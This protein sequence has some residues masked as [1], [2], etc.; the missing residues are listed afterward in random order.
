[1]AEPGPADP[2]R[3]AQVSLPALLGGTRAW[4]LAAL[5]LNGV[6][7]AGT[8]FGTTL[9]VQE[10]FSRLVAGGSRASL[11][12]LLPL[13]AA[14]GAGALLIG[15]LRARERA[16]GER[17]GQS[18]V[19]A[20]RH[21]MYKRLSDL[22]PR[23]L[24]KRSQGAVMLRFVGDLTSIARWVSLGLSR[25]IV[26]GTF[27][28]GA[29]GALAFLSPALAGGVAVIL[30]LG[31]AAALV[32]ARTL[33]ARSRYARRKRSALAANV[34]EK[35][36]AMA[37]VQVYGQTERE[38]L[39]LRSQSR[40]LRSAMVGKAQAAGRLRGITEA[41]ALM[42]SVVALMVGAAQVGSGALTPGTIVAA[43]MIIGLLV[44]PLR[45][46][47]RV[48]EYWHDS[49]ISLEK[50]RS[51]LA[52][53]NLVRVAPDAPQL[54]PGSGR[55]EFDDVYLQGS[56]F[57]VSAVAEPRSLV[58]LVGPNGAGKSTL[59]MLAARL[60]DPDAG[61]VRV[62]GQDLAERDRSSIREAIS[63]TGPDFPLLRGTVA[64]NLCYRSPDASAAELDRV[65][66][67]CSLDGLLS[68]LPDGAETRVVEGGTNLSAG[69]RQRIALA[70]ALVGDPRLLL[71]DEADANLDE[72]A[73]G[74]LERI[75]RTQRG[76]RTIL[77]VSHRPEVL[78]WADVI[79]RMEGGR[80][81]GRAGALTWSS[82]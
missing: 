57:G 69:Q 11:Q 23:T 61:A 56:L 73:R 43:M 68:E 3:P 2:R 67:L 36:A 45:D 81:V 12:S 19:H 47:G 25:T 9:L 60:V 62:D 20:L 1:M 49:R 14:L 22:S 52:T 75:I 50:C 53:P 55:L 27:V 17:L 30:I 34:N 72:E 58:A 7:Q 70:R 21:T 44:N 74:L 28:I 8:A 63:M 35:I 26:G 41:T 39:R 24:Q 77:V 80:L 59:L 46:L 5:V 66:R 71:L 33:Q 10:A 38:R 48:N 15:F 54:E 37:V 42:A 4:R 18:Y 64:E 65:A 6:A 51:F 29:L 79:W 82:P 76:Q 31:G 32:S 13:G 78:E 40:Q 16:D